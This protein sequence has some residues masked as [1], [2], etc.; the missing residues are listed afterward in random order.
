[1]FVL[2]DEDEHI[3]GFINGGISREAELEYDAEVY[4]LYL[5]KEAQGNGYGRLLFNALAEALRAE[6]YNSIMTWVLEDNPSL[7][8]Y[9]RIGAKEIMSKSIQI[10][11]KDLVEIAVGWKQL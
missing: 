1:M 3:V 2:V 8:F 11:S 10:G 4:A 6:N 5:L 7:G 9:K